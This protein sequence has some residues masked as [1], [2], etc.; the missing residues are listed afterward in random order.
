M[1]LLISFLLLVFLIPSC[2][3]RN[4]SGAFDE[5]SF[6]QSESLPVSE[7]FET[8]FVKLSTSD[9]CLIGTVNQIE[10]VNEHFLVLDGVVEKKLFL[11]RNNGIF[12]KQIGKNGAGPGEYLM[13]ISFSID[14]SKKQL[15]IIDAV[16]RKV[17]FYDLSNYNFL[18]E[19]KLPFS[20]T[21]MEWLSENVIAWYSSSSSKGDDDGYVIL[22]DSSFQIKNRMLKKDFKTAYYVGTKPKLYKN[23]G[24]LSVY[25]PFVSEIYRITEDSLRLSYRLSFGNYKMA[26]IEF[27][28]KEGG[29]KGNYLSALR[30]SSYIYYYTVNENDDVLFVPYYVNETMFYGVYCKKNKRIYNYTKEMIQNDLLVGAFSSPVGSD[31][32]GSFISLLRPSLLM[33]LD[34]KGVSLDK[35]LLSLLAN[36]KEED[37]PILLIYKTKI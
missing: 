36:S 17:L 29:K 18:F 28:K 14:N 8:S 19:M 31:R 27:L 2:T 3:K 23:S 12:L 5:I 15:T 37:N 11:F 6:G 30:N 22:T 33:E 4:Q 32:N 26:P 24:C 10:E 1:K 20:S 34:K 13:P 35:R 21:K 25:K 16:G 7:L 9:E